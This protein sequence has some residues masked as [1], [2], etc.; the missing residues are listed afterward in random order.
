MSDYLDHD[1]LTT[2]ADALGDQEL[3]AETVGLYLGEL[4]TRGHGIRDAAERG[5]LVTLRFGA[6]TLASPSALLGATELSR[7]CRHLELDEDV[8]DVEVRRELVAEF[9]RAY[10]GTG[11]ALRAWLSAQGSNR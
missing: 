10:A 6:H 11:A 4:P 5:D 2:L 7:V 1:V 3:M 8:D 9:D